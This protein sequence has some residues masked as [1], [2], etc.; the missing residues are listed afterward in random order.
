[1][2]RLIAAIDRKNG[3]AKNL[4]MPWCIPEDEKYF[5]DQ[6]KTYGGNVL[7]GKTTFVETYHGNPLKN[8]QN[9]IVTH[10]PAPIEGAIVV[11]D[12]AK[13]LEE[14]KD[15]LWVAGGGIVFEEVMKL[16]RADE[17]YLT[18]IDADFGC[19]TLFPAYEDFELAEQGE[20]REQNGF[21]FIYAVYRRR[22][23]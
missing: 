6:T 23:T 20:P 11:N 18:H 17:L 15:D 13:F 21:R 2:I 10:D 5:T 9:Y 22:A 7:T 12:L 3:L 16:G 4:V 8:R 1:M 19:D 14:F